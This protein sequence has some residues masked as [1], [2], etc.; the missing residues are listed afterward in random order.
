MRN[1]IL[2]LMVLLPCTAFAG[3]DCRVVEYADHYE[4]ICDGVA[5]QAP[6][7]S[8]KKPQDQPGVQDQTVAS[9]NTP[10][11]EQADAPI[12]RNELARLHAALWL[13]SRP[14]Q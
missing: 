4:A 2:L 6:A 10:E 13:K 11:S 8:P 14:V 3:T 5:E 9:G 1:K 7:S 12:V